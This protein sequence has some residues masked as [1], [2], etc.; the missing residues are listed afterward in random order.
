MLA[1]IQRPH[2]KLLGALM[3]GT[4]RLEL[5]CLPTSTTLCEGSHHVRGLGNRAA[6][7]RKESFYPFGHAAIFA[8]SENLCFAQPRPVEGGLEGKR[9][10]RSDTRRG[11][12]VPTENVLGPMLAGEVDV[13]RPQ[14]AKLSYATSQCTHQRLLK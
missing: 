6:R 11:L 13:L 4:A 12:G 14:N 8:S 5:A 9:P 1:R 2:A 10:L 3:T 7:L